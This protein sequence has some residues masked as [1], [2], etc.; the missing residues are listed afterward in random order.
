M[1]AEF[2]VLIRPRISPY[3]CQNYGNHY[4]NSRLVLRTLHSVNLPPIPGQVTPIAVFE[5]SRD[6]AETSLGITYR[7]VGLSVTANC[8]LLIKREIFYDRQALFL[9]KDNA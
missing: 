3:N 1:Q 6:F 4:Q 5:V 7:N 9:I 2:R 8:Q